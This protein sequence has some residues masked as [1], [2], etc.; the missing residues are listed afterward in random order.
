MQNA[1]KTFVSQ[2]LTDTEP[3]Q[4]SI[5]VIPYSTQ[6]NA[7]AT[8]LSQFAYTADHNYSHCVDFGATDYSTVALDPTATLQ[9]TGHF[10]P[11]TSYARGTFATMAASGRS[12]VWVCRTES[13]FEIT[14]WAND[15]TAIHNQIDGFTAGGNTS[16]DVAVKW[17]AA[18]LDPSTRPVFDNLQDAGV[19]SSAFDAGRPYA[20]DPN[21]DVLKFIVV[22]T[23]GINTTQFMLDDAYSSGPSGVWK[24]PDTGR[25]SMYDEE[26]NDWDGDGDW[27]E[28]VWYA[29]NYGFSQ[30]RFLGSTESIDLGTRNALL[31]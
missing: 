29:R 30:V 6:V 10:D 18:L 9:Q 21:D 27:R 15:I 2:V 22:M 25:Y 19:V 24:D 5:N 23:D 31:N 16:I 8:L 11:W 20:H 14:P 3:G 7:G 4:V 26:Y 13:D 17:G 1:A 12:P 28:D